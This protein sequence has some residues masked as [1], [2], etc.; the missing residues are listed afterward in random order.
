MKRWITTPVIEGNTPLQAHTNIPSGQYEREHGHAGFI[1]ASS[2]IYHSHKPCN[3][4]KSEGKLQHH[5]FNTST[6]DIKSLNPWQSSILFYNDDICIRFWQCPADMIELA[7]NADG[8]DLLFMHAGRGEFYCDY[9]HFSVVEGDYIYIPKG[10]MWRIDTQSG[11]KCLMIEATQQHYQLPDKTLLG[12]HAIFDPAVLEHPHIDEHYDKQ[13]SEDSWIINI[14][15]MQS[16]SRLHYPYNP[17]DTVGWHGNLMPVRININDIRPV[18]SHR[19]HIPPSVHTTF[20]TDRF[21]VSTFVPRP[22][23]SADDA[24][25]VPFF[26]NNDD[27]DEVIFYHA[28]DFFSRDNITQGMITLHP[29]GVTH[30]PHP[31]AFNKGLEHARSYTDEYAVMIDVRYP[32]KI[33]EAATGIELTDYMSSWQENNKS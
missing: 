14:K 21:M 29:A 26:H 33:T 31:D 28:G 4:L 30:G 19:Y 3:W 16:I 5:A 27:Y 25:K 18:T 1:G 9:G 17:L 11:F 12:Q 8:D 32:L 6:I 15:Y 10:T 2:H 20:S 22:I 7:R 23:E 13:R 24:L